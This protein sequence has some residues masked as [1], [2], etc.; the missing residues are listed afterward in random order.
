MNIT[1]LDIESILAAAEKSF[2]YHQMR[3]SGQQISVYDNYDYH[4]IVA[5]CKHFWQSDLVTENQTLKQ[6]VALWKG[7]CDILGGD[8]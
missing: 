6:E 2:R 3:V 7:R 4:I 5:T 1:D 8:E